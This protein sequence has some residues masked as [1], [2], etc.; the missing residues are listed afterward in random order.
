MLKV[1]NRVAII[2]T[3]RKYGRL[4]ILLNPSN[5][6][7]LHL[8]QT[9]ASS[10]AISRGLLCV[11]VPIK[12]N[13]NNASAHFQRVARWPFARTCSSASARNRDCI[14]APGPR[15]MAAL[16]GFNFEKIKR[17]SREHCNRSSFTGLKY[18]R[19]VARTRITS[20]R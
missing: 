15:G 7:F 10:D 5:S 4:Y 20:Q 18:S 14:A 19:T 16:S 3:W 11:S 17:N 12:K 13:A 2:M 1:L 8:Q 9:P 6:P